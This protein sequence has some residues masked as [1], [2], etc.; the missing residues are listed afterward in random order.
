MKRGRDPTALMTKDT[1]F[2]LAY[3]EYPGT[4]V[5]KIQSMMDLEDVK[6]FKA[7]PNKTS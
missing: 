5:D 6:S 3:D 7:Q 1:T 2:A 4:E